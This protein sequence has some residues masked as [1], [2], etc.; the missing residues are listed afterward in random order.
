MILR[1]TRA[2]PGT[3]L[4]A[5][6]AVASFVGVSL[7]AAT[8]AKAACSGRPTDPNGYQGYAYG[9]AEVNSYATAQARVHWAT[10]G[11]HAPNLT[12]TRPDNVPDTVAF[13]ADTAEDVLTR[14][15]QMGYRKVP[16]DATCTSNGGD[17]KVDIYL[18]RFVGADGSTVPECNGAIC[19]SFLL[20]ES[21]FKAKG[22]ANAQ[23]GFRT[24]IAHELFHAIQ[25]VYHPRPEPFWAEG[26]AQW[27]M[28]TLFPELLDFERQL[29]A[30]FSDNARSID[31]APSGVTAG[32]LYGASVWPLFLSLEHGPDTI[33]EILELEAEGQEPLPAADAVLKK[34]GSSLAE[35]FPVFAAWNV[36]TGKLA[37]TGGYPNAATY[38]GVKIDTLADGIEGITS[39]LAYFAYKGTLDATYEIALETDATRNGGVLVPI[40]HGTL[41]LDR[42]Q[43]LPASAEGEV[44]VVVAGT[45]TKKTDAKFKVRFQ[46]PGAGSS[47]SSSSG[48]PSGGSG[49]DGCR[50]APRPA[51]SGGALVFAGV[52]AAAL[53]ALRS[54]RRR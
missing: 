12:S 16:S 26:T 9:S 54:R 40:D 53:A 4:V 51:S 14:Y 11:T 44:L 45:T 29:P 28:K 2:D 42:A 32:F 18:V 37:S 35:A 7:L 15:A 31:A 3:K 48:A 21:T 22:Y 46:A 52:A 25:N 30:F 34:K 43:K 24:V 5:F 33:R 41:R 23:E 17:E 10:S 6:A 36:G 8:E 13:A 19:S 39:G 20:V 38:P 1:T 50:A 49:S 27:G 47:A